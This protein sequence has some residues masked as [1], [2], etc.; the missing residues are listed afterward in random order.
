[1]WR[2]RHDPKIFRRAT[3]NQDILIIFVN[4]Q[5][6]IVR[7]EVEEEDENG[8]IQFIYEER[9]LADMIVYVQADEDILDPAD[10]SVIYKKEESIS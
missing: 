8:N 10:N 6:S 1:M 5:D 9:P 7:V 4:H 2:P 3:S